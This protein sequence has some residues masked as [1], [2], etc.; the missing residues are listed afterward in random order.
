[1]VRFVPVASIQC[2]RISFLL[3]LSLSL[4]GFGPAVRYRFLGNSVPV[5]MES[6]AKGS[7]VK[8]TGTPLIRSWLRVTFHSARFLPRSEEHTSE[9]QSPYDLVCRLLLD[10]KSNASRF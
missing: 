8:W 9:L 1:M 2:P 6:A 3:I 4:S 10:N 7:L 5:H